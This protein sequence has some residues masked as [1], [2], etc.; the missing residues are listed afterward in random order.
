MCFAF[1]VST[2]ELD[3]LELVNRFGASWGMIGGNKLFPKKILSFKTWTP[4]VMYHMMNSGH[5]ATILSEI[6]PI[7]IEVRDKADAEDWGYKDTGS[8]IPERGIHL[9][10]P[11]IHGQ[12]TTVFSGWPSFIQHCQK[13][14][15]LD[16]AVE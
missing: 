8:D 15:H 14:L 2:D 6:R 12:E 4:V 5:H 1:A 9:I 3:T 7:L 13:Y 11:K 10:V 16:C